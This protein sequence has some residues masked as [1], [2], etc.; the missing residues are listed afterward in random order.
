LWCCLH[1]AI[2]GQGV[3]ATDEEICDCGAVGIVQSWDRAFLLLLRSPERMH[4]GC[5][6]DRGG[7]DRV[8]SGRC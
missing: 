7:D 8:V 6:D 2:V 5:D 1:G 3:P 4:A